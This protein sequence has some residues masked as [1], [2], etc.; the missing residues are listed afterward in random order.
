LTPTDV[1]AVGRHPYALSNREIVVEHWDGRR[2]HARHLA[3]RAFAGG[4]FL[5]AR[6]TRDV[7]IAANTAREKPLILHYDGRSWTRMPKL[8]ALHELGYL[9]DTVAVAAN[10]AW[11]VGGESIPPFDPLIFH[12]NGT[13]WK[14]VHAA[15]DVGYIHGLV[16]LRSHDLWAVGGK[17]TRPYGSVLIHWNGTMW[18]VVNS[19]LRWIGLR[20]LTAVSSRDLW[21]VGMTVPKGESD[22]AVVT[23]WNGRAFRVV[24]RIGRLGSVVLVDIS[25]SGRHVW[26]VG[27]RGIEQWNGRGWRRIR[28]NGVR[29][30]G[31]DATSPSNVWAVGDRAVRD[32]A[33]GTAIYH[34]ACH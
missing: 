21:S 33:Q 27:P 19:E 31:T 22:Q 3:T 8:L 12:W 25:A 4:P 7:W 18:R 17:K 32:S 26:A 28:M 6:S 14:R 2:W 9:D 23:H 24:H 5:S 29:L 30:W 16:A 1:W 11:A 20:S 13:R 34:R 15:L 10:D